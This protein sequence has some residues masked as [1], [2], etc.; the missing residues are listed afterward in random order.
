VKINTDVGVKVVTARDRKSSPAARAPQSYLVEGASKRA[1]QFLK[2]IYIYP[3]GMYSVV[4][5]HNVA[6]H[7][8]FYLE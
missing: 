4:N 2:L 3:E 7:A 6:M 1:L 5:C 8:K